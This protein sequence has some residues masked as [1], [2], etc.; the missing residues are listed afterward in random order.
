MNM[1][2]EKNIGSSEFFNRYRSYF[3]FFIEFLL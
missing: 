3:N 2:Q 1:G